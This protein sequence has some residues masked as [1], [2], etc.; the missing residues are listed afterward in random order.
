MLARLA[1]SGEIAVWIALPIVTGAFLATMARVEARQSMHPLRIHLAHLTAW[2]AIVLV[3]TL[4]A[5]H[6]AQS[7]AL[8]QDFVLADRKEAQRIENLL[9]RKAEVVSVIRAGEFTSYNS[10]KLQLPSC[11]YPVWFRYKET[12][13]AGLKFAVTDVGEMALVHPQWFDDSEL[14]RFADQFCGTRSSL[15]TTN[16]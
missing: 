13:P 15:F 8:K 16:G 3:C 6:A 9:D 11:K 2:L 4:G 14:D 7:T 12:K 1:W 10:A 5:K